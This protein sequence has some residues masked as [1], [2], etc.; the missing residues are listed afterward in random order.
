MSHN[1]Q[2][3][4][5]TAV[6]A[7]LGSTLTKAIAGISTAIGL[8]FG[9]INAYSSIQNDFK[10]LVEANTILVTKEIHQAK[11]DLAEIFHDDLAIR[12]RIKKRTIASTLKFWTSIIRIPVSS[13]FPHRE[14]RISPSLGY[15]SCRVV[16]PFLLPLLRPL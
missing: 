8:V 13:I 11:Y 12:L 15:L 5:Q 16:L 14:D 6:Q 3:P 10:G 4:Q 1:N 7:F 9:I 2:P